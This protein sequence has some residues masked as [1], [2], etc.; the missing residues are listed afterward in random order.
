MPNDGYG[1]S[2]KDHTNVNS[3]NYQ[4]MPA[5]SYNVSLSCDILN[6][7]LR[8]IPGLKYCISNNGLVLRKH[9]SITKILF[10]KNWEQNNIITSNGS[11][12]TLR[13]TKYE[14]SI[15]YSQKK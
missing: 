11:L 6:S 14:A 7:L 13:Y 10:G 12:S 4:Q 9:I 3:I 8:K 1:Y 2:M 5:A 15:K